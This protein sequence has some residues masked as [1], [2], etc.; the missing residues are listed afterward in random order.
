MKPSNKFVV[1]EMEHDEHIH[2]SYTAAAAVEADTTYIYIYVSFLFQKLD[3][4]NRID[5]LNSIDGLSK[6]TEKRI[7]WARE[8]ER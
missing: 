2:D 5:I 8:R 1:V 3:Q 7:E 4:S 6:S